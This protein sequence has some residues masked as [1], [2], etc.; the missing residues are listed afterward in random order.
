MRTHVSENP[1]RDAG[2]HLTLLLRG[3]SQEHILLVLSGGSA[4]ALL[5]YID[6]S[7]LGPHLTICMADE[8]FTRDENGNNF[9]QLTQTE[10]CARAKEAG[11]LFI[12]STPLQD[13]PQQ[14]FTLRMQEAITAYTD[15]HP[16]YYAVGT[17]GIGEDGHTAGIF[18]T[19]EKEFVSI[20][21]SGEFYVSLTQTRAPYP[22]RATVTPTFIDRKSVV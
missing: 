6:P 15:A 3:H 11:C 5:P 10:F 21:R 4:F 13:E 17:F 9:L 1:D 7:V 16:E 8:R 12:D 18:P 19:T 14:Q 22:F 2:E 20:Y